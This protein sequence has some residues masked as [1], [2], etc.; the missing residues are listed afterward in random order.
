MSLK[1]TIDAAIKKAMLAREKDRLEALRAVKAAILIAETEKTNTSGTL[2]E[3]AEVKLLQRLVKQRK[4][5]AE[6]YATQ[7]RQDLVDTEMLQALVIEEYLPKQMDKEAVKNVLQN[8]ILVNNIT[9]IK[10]IGKVMPIASKEL[11]GQTD[12]KVIMELLKQLLN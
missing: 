5:A 9:S 12:N 6:I 8:I 10:E 11:A 7:S 4:E 1:I 2:T 3:D